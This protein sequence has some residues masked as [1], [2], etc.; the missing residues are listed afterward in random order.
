[1]SGHTATLW[2]LIHEAEAPIS[3]VLYS[4]PHHLE[5]VLAGVRLMAP[6][7]WNLA[8]TRL[9]ED[10]FSKLELPLLLTPADEAEAVATLDARRDALLSRTAPVLLFLLQDGAGEQRFRRAPFLASWLHGRV[11]DSEPQQIDIEV[12]RKQFAA[13]TRRSPEDWLEAWR[14]GE[15]PDAPDINPD[16]SFIYLRALFLRLD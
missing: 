11:F 8:R 14:R 13:I 4:D 10:A 7:T 6:D 5:E 2:R 3:L 15:I 1:M 12:A 16:G 9:V